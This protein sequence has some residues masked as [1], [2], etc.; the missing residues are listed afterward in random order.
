MP[1]LGMQDW[2][3]LVAAL[4][5]TGAVAGVLAGLLGVGGGIVIVPMLYY[6]FGALDFPPETRMHVAVGTSL[7]T[8]V[9]TSLASMRA[10]FKRRAVQTALL[11]DFGP[12]IFLGAALGALVAGGVGGT[13]LTAVFASIALLVAVNMSLPGDGL[14]VADG[15]PRRRLTNFGLGGAIGTVSAMM[16]IGGG[17]LSV[18][19]LCLFSYPIHHAVA[20]ASALG[21]LIAIPGTI[22]FAISGLD[23]PNRPLASLGYVNLL[24]AAL[25]V[26]MTVWMAPR[27]A[28]LAHRLKKAWLQR[29][30]A[31]F[32]TLSALR[33]LLPATA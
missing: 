11:R 25:I 14:T 33:M 16:G 13:V 29:A 5:A 2:I 20:T 18:P 19:V 15:L 21:L 3:W 4:L 1:E 10:H 23:V 6:V 31:L 32:L 30:F 17:T 28:A 22:G 9:P 8:I 26:P 24:A 12:A 27:G 7:A